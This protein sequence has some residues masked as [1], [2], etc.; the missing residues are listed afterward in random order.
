MLA[1]R[2]SFKGFKKR[3]WFQVVRSA[4]KD[5][6]WELLRYLLGY[7]A[8]NN[9]TG[10]SV[11]LQNRPFY[12]CVLSCLA[13]NASE[14][15]GFSHLNANLLALEQLHLHNKFSRQ[16]AVIWFN[17]AR[18][19]LKT[20]VVLQEFPAFFLFAKIHQQSL[21]PHRTFSTLLIQVY[22]IHRPHS[23]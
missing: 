13:M 15:G 22:L 18:T 20:T 11:F 14:A 6:Q 4:S 23:V 16:T 9:V 7:G 21:S 19:F 17:H 3:I 2:C 5:P 8:E 12:S 10:D 1:P